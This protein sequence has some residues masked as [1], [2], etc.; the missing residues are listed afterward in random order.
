[1]IKRYCDR[2]GKAVEGYSEVKIIGWTESLHVGDK[3]R[4]DLCTECKN[5]MVKWI[6]EFEKS[7]QKNYFPVRLSTILKKLKKT[8]TT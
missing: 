3:E 7:T 5:L 2:C 8:P 6:Q 4:C 1:M